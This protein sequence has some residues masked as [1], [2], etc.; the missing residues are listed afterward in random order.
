MKRISYW[1][2]ST[3]SAVVLL[4]GFDASRHGVS[5]A[6]PGSKSHQKAQQKQQPQ[7]KS[8]SSQSGSSGGS[9]STVTGSAIQTIYG[10]VQV[11]LLVKGSSISNV[12]VLQYPRSMSY[13]IQLDNYALPT[14]IR[15]TVQA[16]SAHIN[17]VSGAT[18]TSDG[19][20]RSLQSALDKANL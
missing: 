1:L 17:M 9:P 19:Y 5:V 12:R 20:I 2:L 15:E 11:Q 14:L 3:L 13:D 16:Q 4:V 18:Y 7:G 6:A 8:T 10:P